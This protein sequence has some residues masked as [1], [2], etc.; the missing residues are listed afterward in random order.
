[1]AKNYTDAEIRQLAEQV[2]L[3]QS[4]DARYAQERQ[5]GYEEKQRARLYHLIVEVVNNY[6]GYVYEEVVAKIQKLL[7]RR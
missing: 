3:R 6:Y 4:A 5:R 7:S 2:R 1:M